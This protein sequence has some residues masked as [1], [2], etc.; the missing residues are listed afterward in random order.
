MSTVFLHKGRPFPSVLHVKR[1]EEVR[2]Y[3]PE[4]TYRI[5]WAV[6]NRVREGDEVRVT[7]WRCGHVIGGEHVIEMEGE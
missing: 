6:P 7:G 5:R 1:G 3:V 4:R 2:R